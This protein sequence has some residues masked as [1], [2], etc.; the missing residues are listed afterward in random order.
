[1]CATVK[2]CPVFQITPPCTSALTLFSF[3]LLKYSL[4]FGV[5]EFDI[6]D[7]SVNENSQ[8]STLSPLNSGET[9]Y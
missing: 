8:L 2:S 9:P 6:D 1:M 7:I 4:S 5:Q 3:K